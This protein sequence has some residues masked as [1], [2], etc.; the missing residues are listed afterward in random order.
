MGAI[1]PGLSG[2]VLAVIFGLYE[3]LIR[4][5]AH[6]RRNFVR[7]V[8][9]FVPVGIGLVLG[10]VGFSFVVSAAFMALFAPLVTLLL[11]GILVALG[12]RSNARRRRRIAEWAAARGWAVLQP[13]AA[14]L[15]RWSGQ[16]FRGGGRISEVIT[17]SYEGRPAV[18]LQYS[19]ST[20]SGKDRRTHY[21]HVVALALPAPLGRLELTPDDAGAKLAKLFGGPDLDLELEEFNRVWRV[22]AEPAKFG[23]DVLHPRLMERLLA[24]DAR[25]LCLRIGGADVLWWGLGRPSLELVDV[26][27]ALLAEI[28]DSIPPFV[29]QDYGYDPIDAAARRG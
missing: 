19:Y 1:L 10:I 12:V 15:A 7:N 25:G 24:P 28:V 27:L 9:F 18:T 23:S 22:A 3:P 14:F 2:G 20:G 4:F 16:P 21:F 6:L 26:R 5:L 8:L 11:G 17:G 13:D 29:W